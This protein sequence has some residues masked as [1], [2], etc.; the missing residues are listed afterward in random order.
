MVDLADRRVLAEQRPLAAAQLGDVV[1]QH[2][3]A[4]VLTARA[5]RQRPQLH[6]DV[7]ASTSPLPV[8]RPRATTA[9]GSPSGCAAGRARAAVTSASDDPARSPR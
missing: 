9:T 7:A 2:Q 4:D 8:P 6:D 3:R 5:Q 1:H